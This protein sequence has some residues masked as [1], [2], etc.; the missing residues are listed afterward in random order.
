MCN[1]RINSRSVFECVIQFNNY[2]LSTS[3]TINNTFICPFMFLFHRFIDSYKDTMATKSV[4]LFTVCMACILV[5]TSSNEIPEFR[6]PFLSNLLRESRG[7]A[8]NHGKPILFCLVV[9]FTL[10]DIEPTFIYK[11]VFAFACFYLFIYFFILF[12]VSIILDLLL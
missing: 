8:G 2:F 11:L 9:M 1:D 3:K 6:N 12:Y 7:R 4:I 10:K 5:L